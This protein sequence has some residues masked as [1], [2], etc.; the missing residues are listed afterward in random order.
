ML[1]SALGKVSSAQSSESEKKGK[2][3]KKRTTKQK[4]NDSAQNVTIALDIARVR[5]CIRMYVCTHMIILYT[6]IELCV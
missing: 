1:G 4:Q 3:G 6:G 5:I 2:A